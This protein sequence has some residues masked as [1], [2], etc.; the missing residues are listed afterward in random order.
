MSTTETESVT[1]TPGTAL[2]PFDA[3]SLVAL[4][5]R[6]EEF[7]IA[8]AAARPFEKAFLQGQAMR[9]LREMITPEMLEPIKALEGQALGFKTDRWKDGKHYDDD[10]IRDVTIEATLRGYRM[11]GNEVNILSGGFY[12]AKNGCKRKAKEFPGLVGLQ[13]AFGVP[14]VKG[15]EGLIVA[16]SVYKLN[17][18]Q[19]SFDRKPE[20]L[21]DGSTFDN[22]IVVRVNS[23]QIVD[24]VLGKAHR[25]FYAAL[26]EHL[27]GEPVDDGEVDDSAI[28]ADSSPTKGTRSTLFDKE[29]T[30]AAE[31]GPAPRAQG[32]LV[33]EYKK[34]LGECEN[35]NQIGPI[36]KEAGSDAR[37]TTTSRKLISDMCTARRKEL[38]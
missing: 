2:L 16:R 32:A 4:E 28:D 29:A 9:V 19:C 30:E 37:L 7:R 26:L 6:A 1:T 23:G 31:A 38:P 24:A 3:G 17:G 14:E 36:A 10:T 34:K 12:S 33:G 21:S 20:K 18:K 35:K 27:S 11:V 8:I 25:K 15:G 5:D 22:R 13:V